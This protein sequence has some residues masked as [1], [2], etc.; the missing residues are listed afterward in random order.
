M[1]RREELI[2]LALK[3]DGETEYSE[4]NGYTIKEEKINS[5]DKL[6]EEN[7]KKTEAI[8]KNRLKKEGVSNSC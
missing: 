5:E 2:A 4:E 6:T 7:Y 8:L 3:Y 1:S